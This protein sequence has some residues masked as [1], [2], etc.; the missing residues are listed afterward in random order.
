LNAFPT[1]GHSG[2][3]TS[4]ITALKWHQ[5][6]GELIQEGYDKFGG[7]PFK[8]ATMSKWIVVFSG[9]KYVEHIRTA[10]INVLSFR[11]EIAE[12]FQNRY[13]MGR[14]ISNDFYHIE[15]IRSTLTR[16]LGSRFSDIRDEILASFQDFIPLTED[17]TVVPAYETSMHIVCRVANRFF[18]GLPLCRNPGYL[19]LIESYTRDVAVSAKTINSFPEFLKP[20]VGR[21]L[22]PLPRTVQRALGY[23]GPMVEERLMQEEL[24][25]KEWDER[26]ATECLQ[27]LQ[28]DLLTWLLGQATQEHHYTVH[29]LT[30]RILTV[31]FA[32][33]HNT[34]MSLTHA[35]YDLAVHPEHI[36]EL[37]EE[38]EAVVEEDGWTKP[39]LFRMRKVDSFLK[40]SQRLS[41]AST[42]RVNR[43]AL[44]DF[45]FSDGTFIPAGATIGVAVDAMNKEEDLFPE[46]H[47]FKGFRFAEMR[48]G[49]G[50][51]DGIRHQMVSLGLDQIVFGQGRHACPGRFFAVSELKAI[52]AHILLNYDMQL[53]NGSRE[54][55]PHKCLEIL[56]LPDPRAKLMFR[57]RRD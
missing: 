11:A 21:Y 35:L 34:S 45:T 18:V 48:E 25:G 56:M 10:P 29:D 40:E 55:P 27:F 49:S 53:E 33:N 52:F 7:R 43:I 57:K 39:A 17:W 50:E 46:A 16:N 1:V 19:S 51:L 22:T 14:V 15:V 37:R 23:L 38:I 2:V 44:Q 36:K 26:P 13:T 9:T 8:V 47:T 31:N 5:H 3:L 28:N 20:L 12:R 54:R 42:L 6:A 24:H 30:I 4:Y 41:S 32:A